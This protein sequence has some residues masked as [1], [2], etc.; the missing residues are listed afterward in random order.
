[1]GFETFDGVGLNDENV[2]AGLKL[3]GNLEEILLSDDEAKVLEELWLHDRVADAGFVF[4]A[5]ENE[6]LRGAG[7]LTANYISG[8]G[9]DLSFTASREVDRTPDVLEL[10][11]E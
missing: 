2:F 10:R 8:D 6:T 7:A 5:D 3:A 11:S 1:M 9:D 4:K